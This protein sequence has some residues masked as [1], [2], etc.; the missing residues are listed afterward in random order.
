MPKEESIEDTELWEALKA[1][2]AEEVIEYPGLYGTIY[3]VAVEEGVSTK[4][5][6]LPEVQL[7]E[8]VR[9]WVDYVETAPT[10]QVCLCEWITHPD[11]EHLP[12][13][14]Q[15]RKKV[16]EHPRCPVHTKMGY[17]LGFFL[18]TFPPEEASESQP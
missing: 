2:A 16:V 18:F 3:P 12:I 5:Y 14:K 9:K 11:D 17:L 1:D 4:W 8:L 13:P 10:S 6:S 15:R 7:E